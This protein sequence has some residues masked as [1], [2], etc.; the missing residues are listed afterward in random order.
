MALDSAT[1]LL[2]V[3]R[4]HGLL[5]QAELEQ[6]WRELQGRFPLSRELARELVSRGWLT[7]FQVN[8]LLQGR[9]ADLVLGQ[10]VLLDRLG[11]GGMGQ[12]FRARH[13]RLDRLVALKLIRPRLLEDTGAVQRFLREARAAARL[14]HPN[15]VV[16][17][18]ADELAGTHFLV[19]ELVKGTDLHRLVRQ[20]GPLT[21]ARAADCARQT[22]LG[23]QHLHEQGLIHRDI[24]PSNLLL[25]DRQV[26]KI[27]DLGMAGWRAGAVSQGEA[28]L[29]GDGTVMGTPDFMA[30]EQA[31]DAHRADIR[32]DLYSLGCTLYFLLAGRPPFPGGTLTE[33]LL[34]HQQ[35]EP[36]PLERLRPELPPTLPPV[37]RRLM[38]KQPEARYPQPVAAATALEQLCTSVACLAAATTV[39]YPHMAGPLTPQPGPGE[40]LETTGPSGTVSAHDAGCVNGE[41]AVLLLSQDRGRLVRL[42]ACG[43]AL[44]FAGLLLFLVLGRG[45]RGSEAAT[46]GKTLLDFPALRAED[47]FAWQPPELIAVLGE[48][49]WRTWAEVLSLAVSP[50]GRL[51]AGGCRNHQIVLCDAATGNQLG[52][53]QHPAGD[54]RAVAFGA[55][56]TRLISGS[57]D[58]H[59]RLWDVADQRVLGDWQADKDAVNAL[60]VFHDG[61]R[62][63]TGGED[64]QVHLWDLETREEQKGLLDRQHSAEIRGLSISRADRW[65]ATACLDGKVRLW[66]LTAN[67]GPTVLGSHAEG[68]LQVAFSPDGQMLASSGKDGFVRLWETETGK[69]GPRLGKQS[70]WVPALAFAADGKTLASG[71]V[72]DTIALWDLV[73]RA[74]IAEF[75][76]SQTRI[77]AL[78][79]NPV[80]SGPLFAGGDNN[81]IRAWDP[82]RQ[83]ALPAGDGHRGPVLALAFSPNG[84]LLASAGDDATVRL[85]DASTGRLTVKPLQH[86]QVVHAIAFAPDGELL[87][88]GDQ[89]ETVIFWDPFRGEERAR[90]DREVGP[91]TS[92]AFAPDGH[93]LVQAAQRNEV[94]I[95][96]TPDGVQE[97]SLPGHAGG[98]NAVAFARTGRLLAAADG[99]WQ[100]DGEVKLWDWPE[101]RL[102]KRLKGQQRTIRAIAFAPDG[103]TLATGD[104]AGTVRLWDIDSGTTRFIRKG[105]HANPVMALAYSAD[106]QVLA[107]VDQD[108][109]LVLRAAATGEKRHTWKFPGSIHS[110]AFHPDGAY[111]AT[112]NTNGTI[113]LLRLPDGLEVPRGPGP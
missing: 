60:A 28:S 85:W 78:A 68:A 3:L 80:G 94:R 43:G 101:R 40:G 63:A 109:V 106:G 1:A 16:V 93:Y 61:K 79:F 12:V 20:E 48:H 49:R 77:R 55:T 84:K 73:K 97:A 56:G 30:P 10:Y 24:K 113:Y 90:L 50:D 75:P 39:D 88:A 66:D 92:L 112:G 27:T 11:E 71:G 69:E 35:D 58:G 36:E 98:V 51:V 5:P 46:S 70:S 65:L 102:L 99:D 107:S 18:D 62:L 95:W 52:P 14:S 22:A 67:R 26:V 100:T 33:K 29:T 110:L 6:I 91:V 9:A 72:D 81:E 76:A 17:H 25:T 87:A 15:I 86:R 59:V 34:R 13:R 44:A 23:L 82:A 74:K 19:M 31:R 32:A 38:A 45:E 96:K 104:Y 89:D 83:R 2:E 7:P 103:N 64:G 108:G 54:V 57:N 42:A 37:V 111:L 47:R 105:D 53:L 41:R 8:R 4:Q 21:A